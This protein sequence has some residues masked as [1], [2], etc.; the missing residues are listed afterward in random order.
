MPGVWFV[1][2][3]WNRLGRHVVDDALMAAAQQAP[4][5]VGAHSSKADHCELH[6]PVL[7]CASSFQRAVASDQRVGGAVMSEIRLGLARELRN[8]ALR[9]RLA[10]LDA[11][12]V[13]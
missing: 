3:L 7:L 6:E 8:D 10:E 5:H 13:E 12:L 11:P 2:D 9:Q 4:R 1:E